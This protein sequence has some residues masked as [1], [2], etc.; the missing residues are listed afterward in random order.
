MTRGRTR[1]EI[2]ADLVAASADFV[3][4]HLA[5]IFDKTRVSDERHGGVLR[6]REG[7][8]GPGRPA[9]P[10]RPGGARRQSG[11]RAPNHPG[12]RHRR[13]R[14][15]DQPPGRHEGATPVPD[16]QRGHPRVSGRAPRGRGDAHRRGDRSILSSASAA[17]ECAIAIQKAF[18]RRN[19]GDSTEAMQVRIGINAGEPVTA[20]GRLFGAAV[21]IAFGICGRAKP[22]QIFVA[23]A[24][25]QL[26]ADNGLSARRSR[27]VHVHGT[28][29]D[30]SRRGAVAERRCLT[31][32]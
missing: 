9:P 7:P 28:E 8:G 11:S 13:F 27:P 20:E 23:D 25:A 15:A 12:E 3:A 22:G 32:Q 5:S 30:R 18:A 6:P 16:P 17:V 4:G 26:L 24:V 29:P 21:Q 31:G 19:P 1:E 14:R 2:A 10:L